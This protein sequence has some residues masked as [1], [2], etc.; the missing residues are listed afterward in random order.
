MPEETKTGLVRVIGRWTLVG[1]VL[2]SAIGSGIFGL[3]SLVSEHVGR[4]APLA[5]L[6]A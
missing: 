6:V 3:P 1:L 4:A 5:Y 2:N